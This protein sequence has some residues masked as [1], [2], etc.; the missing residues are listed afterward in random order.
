VFTSSLCLL[1][2]Y[3]DEIAKVV[4]MCKL[5]EGHMPQCPIAGD[6]NDW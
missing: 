6:A 5:Q 2:L 3:I 1:E 4:Y